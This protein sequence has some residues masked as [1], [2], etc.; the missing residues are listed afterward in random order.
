MGRM[1]M[2]EDQKRIL[3]SYTLAP[4]TV[5][6]LDS[7]RTGTRSSGQYIDEAVSVMRTLETIGNGKDAGYFLSE[8]INMYARLR[9][10]AEKLGKT[11]TDDWKN[12]MRNALETY[13]AKIERAERKKAK[14]EAQKP[15]KRA[16]KK[17]NTTEA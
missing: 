1:K 14:E 10:E 7:A 13:T 6:Q 4:E 12:V 2:N 8:L 3:K 9:R 15:R 11:E 16:Q 5:L 17:E